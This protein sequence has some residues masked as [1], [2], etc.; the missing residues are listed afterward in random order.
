MNRFRSVTIFHQAVSSPRPAQV[1]KPFVDR[2]V[3]NQIEDRTISDVEARTL[4]VALRDGRLTARLS[5]T[6][7]AELVGEWK[8]DRK[9]VARRLQIAR[10]LVGF[11]G[12][13]KEADDLFGDV[14]RAYADGLSQPS[15]V[16]P[17]AERQQAV[18]VFGSAA[19]G[20]LKYAGGL[21]QLVNDVRTQ[22]EK[23]KTSLAMSRERATQR[24]SSRAFRKSG[25]QD[26]WTRGAE[27]W[28]GI[29]ADRFNLRESCESRGL[30]GLVRVRPMRLAVLWWMSLIFTHVAR[31]RKPEIGDAYDFY[32]AILASTAEV[33]LTCDRRFAG[34]LSAVP[35][36]GFR[37]VRSVP[38]LLAMC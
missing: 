3:F 5:L 25:F 33:F 16:L 2:N 9:A 11:H 30:A 4:R 15:P 36:D 21:S 34:H 29:F 7:L 35:T 32:H 6:N 24:L 19:S 31:G 1:G 26:Y 14:L 12:L 23:L 38:D 20:N 37:V 28:A 27:E 13:L 17:E 10:D 8:Y 22:R 18:R